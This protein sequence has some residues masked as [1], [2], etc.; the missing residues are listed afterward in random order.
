MANVKIGLCTLDLHLP[1]IASLK[2]KRGIL[3]S[4]LNKLNNRFNVSTSEIDYHD[5]WQSAQI[6][7][8]TV[9]NSNRHVEQMLNKAIVFIETQYPEA[10]I[11]KQD[12]EIL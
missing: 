7:I 6:A 2:A 11:I 3:K 5:T 9:S 12:I 4:M 10:M 1:G 8:T